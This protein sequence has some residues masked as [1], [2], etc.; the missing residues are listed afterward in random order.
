M[1]ELIDM[2]VGIQTHVC[3][4]NHVLGCG[5]DP[6]GKLVPRGGWSPAEVGPQGKLDISRPIVMS[7]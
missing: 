2:P 1:A 4:K 6:Q 7:R 5:F 3:L